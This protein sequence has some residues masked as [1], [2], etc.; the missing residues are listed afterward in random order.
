MYRPL[1]PYS[2]VQRSLPSITCDEDPMTSPSKPHMIALRNNQPP[3]APYLLPPS[4]LPITRFPQN[5]SPMLPW[6]YPQTRRGDYIKASAQVFLLNSSTSSYFYIYQLRLYRLQRR[7]LTIIGWSWNLGD[8]NKSSRILMSFVFWDGTTACSWMHIASQSLKFQT[9]DHWSWQKGVGGIKIHNLSL[10]MSARSVGPARYTRGCHPLQWKK[11]ITTGS[12]WQTQHCMWDLR[13]GRPERSCIATDCI[14][15]LRR[16]T[17]T[18]QFNTHGSKRQPRYSTLRNI[19]T[20]ISTFINNQNAQDT[21][22]DHL[23]LG[24]SLPT[25]SW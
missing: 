24:P 18:P 3:R 17:L 19:Y 4:H 16:W 15:E 7:F 6:L 9:I 12:K 22:V 11:Y 5:K 8:K 1:S 25:Q 20:S 14:S 21:W 13:L 10:S 23:V 2:G